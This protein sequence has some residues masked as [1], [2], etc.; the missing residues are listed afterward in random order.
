M[1]SQDKPEFVNDFLLELKEG[2]DLAMPAAIAASIIE[3][4]AFF[5]CI[6]HGRYLFP[7]LPFVLSPFIFILTSVFD[8]R[9][10][11][12]NMVAIISFL[13]F[14][15]LGV[16]VLYC[17]F[18]LVGNLPEIAGKAHLY[19]SS[20]SERRRRK[21]EEKKALQIGRASCRERVCVPV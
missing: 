20:I 11:H 9:K 12:R 21:Q 10:S 15:T 1:S 18:M 5:L 13:W 14:W 6:V 8:I 16:F 4:A 7:L 19:L 2:V 3:L 17:L